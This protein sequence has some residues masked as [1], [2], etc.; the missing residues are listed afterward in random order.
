MNCS[1]LYEHISAIQKIEMLQNVQVFTQDNTC[2]K[3]SDMV[4]LFL[5]GTGTFDKDI[6]L[7]ENVHIY[8]YQTKI[9]SS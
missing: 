2:N 5:H 7:F 3:K 6:V 4:N 9:F 1:A 8:I